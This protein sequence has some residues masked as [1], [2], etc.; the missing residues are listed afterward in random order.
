VRLD[1]LAGRTHGVGGNRSG[2]TRVLII[3]DEALVRA[4]LRMILESADDIDVV[5]EAGDGAEAVEAVKRC[6][7]DVVLMDIR[8]PRLD[9]LAATTAVR[10]LDGAPPV[11]ILTTFDL[12]DYVFRALQ[13]GAAGFLLK[14]TPPL[15]LVQ[16]VRVVASG[17]SMLSPS[18]TRRLIAHFAADSRT[19]RKQQARDR[20]TELSP[21]EL[22]V[23][24][25]VGR[26]LSNA[27]I[28]AALFM[29]EATVKAHVSRL[30]VKLRQA[31]RVQIAILAHD[32][33]LVD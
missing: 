14:D 8:M 10:E 30:L 19:S 6:K 27:E 11:V 32:A 3:D 23:F 26:G 31:N 7:P 25:E 15:E 21:R 16:A 28:G 13:A 17:E 2:M 29:S 24:T 5:G 1:A 4:G 12:D 22:E 20:L 18:V 9:G 33:G